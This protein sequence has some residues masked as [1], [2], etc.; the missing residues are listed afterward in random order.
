MSKT[1]LLS[2]AV[3]AWLLWCVPIALGT[4]AYSLT[5]KEHAESY[6]TLLSEADRGAF[7]SVELEGG[8]EPGMA[9]ALYADGSGR[10]LRTPWMPV[11]Q[12]VRDMDDRH[13]ALR[14]RAPDPL[15]Q[16]LGY[17]CTPF[18]FLGLIVM[19][20]RWR[21]ASTNA[22]QDYLTAPT[23]LWLPESAPSADVPELAP[24]A[25][26]MRL[27]AQSQPGP[28]RFLLVGPSGSGKTYGARALAAAHKLPVIVLQAADVP[29]MFVGVAPGRISHAWAQALE[30]KPAVLLIEQVDL[31]TMARVSSHV[32]KDTTE[33][34]AGL[35]K[36]CELLEAL[37]GDAS[38]V[39]V[40]STNRPDLLDPMLTAP[41]RIDAT[42]ALPAR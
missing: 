2:Q 6:E 3:K 33:L 40:L 1:P 17:L 13:V 36:L 18:L 12:I 22:V 35:M 37:P 5:N 7:S 25:D 41:H 39:V 38:F 10:G 4:A 30:K 23:Q 14:L 26:A 16:T 29:M 15:L 24:L 11:Y 27:C 28:S 31:L 8:K 19:W 34:T 20:L 32:D 42:L 9:R 21:A